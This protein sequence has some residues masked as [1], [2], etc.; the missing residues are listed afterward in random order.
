MR[1]MSHHQTISDLLSAGVTLMLFLTGK[2]ISEVHLLDYHTLVSDMAYMGSII[3][4]TITI[5]NNYDKT[6]SNIKKIFNKR[7]NK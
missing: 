5:I 1:A 2:L 7:K 3:V 4:A 6:K